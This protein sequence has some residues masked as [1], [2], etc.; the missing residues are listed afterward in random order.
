MPLAG[1][2]RYSDHLVEVIG[3]AEAAVARLQTVPA[4]ERAAAACPA[5][6]AA[7]RLSARL[8]ASPLTDE[9]ADAV[10]AG[11]G[12]VRVGRQPNAAAAGAT[13]GSWARTLR[14]EGVP[15]QD[16]AA[17]E[18]AN[19]LAAA[20]AEPSLAVDLFV[21]PLATL[22]SL[23]R[24]LT[25]GLVTPGVAGRPR[26]TAQS[27]HDGAQGASLY[28]APDPH[29]V[30]GLL[31]RLASWLERG[32][33]TRPTVV[34]A[35]VVHGRLLEWQPFEAANGRLARAA[36]RLVLRARGLDPEGVI[37]F[38]REL[39]ADAAGY[40]AEVGATIRRGGDLSRWL[41]RWAEAVS[42]AAET[43]ADKLAPAPLVEPPTRARRVAESVPAG[44]ELTLSGYA[45]DAEVGL[46]TARADL[47]ALERA[48]LTRLVAGTQ[49]LRWQRR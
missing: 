24:Q 33:A 31:D 26:Q 29:A 14:L 38:E 20:E 6:R 7:A 43:A 17:V 27:V 41:E 28:H 22:T 39:A 34:V 8:D 16:L 5:R 9:T 35:G 4:A 18:Y 12:P 49:G 46:E 23:H 42:A 47:R 2:I 30:P 10:D 44:G 25:A 3:R 40:Y 36:A 48:G 45:R 15:S 21:Q 32:A 13:S 1:G 37:V 11:H 19:L